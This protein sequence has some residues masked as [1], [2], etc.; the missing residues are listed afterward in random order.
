MLQKGGNIVSL[1][2]NGPGY[3]VIPTATPNDVEK[4]QHY[5]WRLDGPKPDILPSLIA[6]G[7]GE[8]WWKEWKDSARTG[9]ETGIPGN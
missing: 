3:E 1:R 2:K 9:L 4:A 8:C 5:L 7:M 6:R